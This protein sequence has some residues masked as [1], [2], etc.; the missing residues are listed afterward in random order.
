MKASLFQPL[1]IHIPILVP[2]PIP[3]KWPSLIYLSL[4]EWEFLFSCEGTIP[5]LH[6]RNGT[7]YLVEIE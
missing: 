3:L 4:W 6:V 2:L 1:P 7:W 5:N